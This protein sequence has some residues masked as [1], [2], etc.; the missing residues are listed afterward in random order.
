MNLSE[1]FCTLSHARHRL[2]LWHLFDVCCAAVFLFCC[3]NCLWWCCRFGV[4]GRSGAVQPGAAALTKRV[5][6]WLLDLQ[7]QQGSKAVKVAAS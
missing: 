5:G 4:D 7:K 6:R 3:N 1:Q 2:L